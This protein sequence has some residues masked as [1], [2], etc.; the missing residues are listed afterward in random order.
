VGNA[1]A[2]VC[3]FPARGAEVCWLHDHDGAQAE[4]RRRE[5]EDLSVPFAE[6][7]DYSREP[8]LALGKGL[9]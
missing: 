9:P 1:Q 3:R 8:H 7:L 2:E 6:P 5:V 4:N